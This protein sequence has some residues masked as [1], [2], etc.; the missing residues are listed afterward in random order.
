ME[1]GGWSQPVVSGFT[2]ELLSFNLF[3]PGNHPNLTVT[4]K[5]LVQTTFW[6]KVA[7]GKILV[8]SFMADGSGNLQI[9][10]VPNSLHDLPLSSVDGGGL[11]QEGVVRLV[12]EEVGAVEDGLLEAGVVLANV[13]WSSR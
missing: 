10:D 2:A 6:L 3:Q 9:Y 4:L 11:E 13:V 5:R 7:V 12:V 1:D 8:V